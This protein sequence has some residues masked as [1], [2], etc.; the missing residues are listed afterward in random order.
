MALTFE[1]DLENENVK[2]LTD[3]QEMYKKLQKTT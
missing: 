2:I 3:P 1:D